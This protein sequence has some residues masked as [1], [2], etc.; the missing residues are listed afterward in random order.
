MK[1]CPAIYQASLDAVLTMK[2]FSTNK[3]GFVSACRNFCAFVTQ[4]TFFKKIN[5]KVLY[6]VIF[7]DALGVKQAVLGTVTI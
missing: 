6:R 2:T 1:G 4:V 5:Y 3:T 7:A